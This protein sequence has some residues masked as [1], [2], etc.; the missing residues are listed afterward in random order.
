MHEVEAFIYEL[1]DNQRELM[2]YFHELLCSQPH[3]TA[4][5]RYRVPFYYR[6]SWICYL[7]PKKGDRIEVCFIRANELSN[8]QGVLDF[9]DRT[10]VAGIELGSV[11]EI[12]EEA[13][14]EVIQEALLLDDVTPYRGPK[15]KK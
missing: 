8:E 2:L 10:Q 9:K 5:I 14:Y 12:P 3:V 13:V 11:S 6:K 7:S 4:K 1:E 15:W